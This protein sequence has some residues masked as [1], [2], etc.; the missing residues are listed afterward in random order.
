MDN[1]H[2]DIIVVGGGPAG[3]M[4]AIAAAQQGRSVCLVEKGKRL[5]KKLIISGGGRCNVTNRLPVEEIIAH[6]PGNGR[7]LYGAFAQFN[8][9]D[10][11]RF[12]QERG[13]QLK[14]E[15]HGRMFPVDDRSTTI[16]HTLEKELQQLN[17]QL[18]MNDPVVKISFSPL[19][20]TLELSSSHF[21]RSKSI[22][23]AVGGKAVPETGS[24]GDGY[25]WAQA[26]GHTITPLFPTEVPIVSRSNIIEGRELQGLSLRN[27]ALTVYSHKGKRII[28]HRGDMIFTHFGLSGPA[29]LRCSQFVVKEL[30][31]VPEKP[32]QM[33]IDLYPDHSEPQLMEEIT[34]NLAQE[35]KRSI[36][37]LLKPYIPERMINPILGFAQ[38]QPDIIG[39]SLQQK[40]WQELVH[41][42]KHFPIAVHGTLPLEKAFVT[43]GGVSIKEIDPKTMGS[44]LL[45]GLYFAGE[46][47]DIHG[48]T[49]GYNITAALVTGYVAG[50]HAAQWVQGDTCNY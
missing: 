44:R 34:Q 22:I 32:V 19:P 49:G 30:A 13:V 2:F 39:D 10:I 41:L 23:V 28:T 12:F 40:A 48:Y 33:E 14:E 7:F 24:T 15:D 4:A 38:I 18:I 29:A 45:P 35:G 11:I 9:E 25:A 21:I 50:L 6:L 8:N 43:G 46:I 42:L 3:L 26:A 37:N 16:L 36:R 17:V 27:I 20:F 1:R 47:L 31:K 5:G